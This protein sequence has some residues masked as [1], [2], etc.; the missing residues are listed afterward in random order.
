VA[1]QQVNIL[2]FGETVLAGTDATYLI[3]SIIVALVI[4]GGL[5]VLYFKH[6]PHHYKQ[7]EHRQ[8][9]ARMI[10]DHSWCE[11]VDGKSEGWFKDL[12]KSGKK[13]VARFPRI[14]YRMQNGVITLTVRITMDKHQKQLAEL[15]SK[16]EPGLFCET[17]RKDYYEGYICYEFLYNA[18]LARI[19]I[20]DVT[21]RD[22][23]MKLMHHM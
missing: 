7:L 16:I 20:G 13:K 10:L 22:G 15:E 5:G 6:R 21:V 8:A 19:G 1:W 3:V 17:V 12:G 2:N 18:E 14:W 9:I 23:K 11:M 4:C